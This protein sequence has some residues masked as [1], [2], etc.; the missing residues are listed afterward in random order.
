MK[1]P[2]P[3]QSGFTLVETLVAILMLTLTMG[4][5]FTLASGGLFSVRYAR[6]Q[7]VANNLLQETIESVRNDR[8]TAVQNN[9]P[10]DA[11][12][13]TY[14]VDTNGSMQDPGDLSSGCFSSNGCTVDSYAG[15]VK[16]CSTDSCQH[17]TFYPNSNFYGYESSYPG[18]QTNGAYS[19][20]YARKIQFVSTS[21]PDQYIVTGEI[22]WN[23]G[24]ATKTLTQSMLLTKWQP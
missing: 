6:N 16:A 14:N 22:K 7:L 10:W 5:L 24:T 15:T 12:L 3:L 18:V 1:K 11:W 21:N 20:S 8:D 23:N 2:Q 4:A 19:T 9:V 17:L 13:G